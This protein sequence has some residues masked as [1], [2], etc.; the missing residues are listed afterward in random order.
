VRVGRGLSG[1]SCQWEHGTRSRQWPMV[2]RDAVGRKVG[3]SAW[4]HARGWCGT[5]RHAWAAAGEHSQWASMGSADDG[6]D[7]GFLAVT[8]T[9]RGACASVRGI[10]ERTRPSC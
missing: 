2:E 6:G 7:V 10:G 3:D 4:A 9:V 5:E 1:S 8:P